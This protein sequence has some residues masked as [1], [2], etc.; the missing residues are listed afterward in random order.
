MTWRDFGIALIAAFVG[1]ALGAILAI[2]LIKEL[3][4]SEEVRNYSLAVVA[5]LGLA[6]LGGVWAP[7]VKWLGRT[8]GRPPVGR[9]GMTTIWRSKR[10]RWVWMRRGYS[11]G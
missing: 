4:L 5:I 2:A 8:G 6:F 1:F 11:S 7:G 3:P 9:R 10:R